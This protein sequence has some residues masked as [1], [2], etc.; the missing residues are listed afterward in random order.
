M[1][2]LKFVTALLSTMVVAVDLSSKPDKA[3]AF[4]QLEKELSPE[5]EAFR[6]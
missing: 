6:R 3:L 1:T 5:E 2:L 4:A